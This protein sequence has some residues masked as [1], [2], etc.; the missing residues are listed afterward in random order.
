M[1]VSVSK[2]EY[3]QIRRNAGPAAEESKPEP[4]SKRDEIDRKLSPERQYSRPPESTPQQ[5]ASTPSTPSP[6]KSTAPS[7]QATPAAPSASQTAPVGGGKGGGAQRGVT[8]AF[9]VIAVLIAAK[10]S[11]GVASAISWI[12]A[13]AKKAS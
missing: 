13:P 2:E 8:A 5:P 7:P 12:K 10:H 3:E 6:A 4:E 1:P 11:A 9:L